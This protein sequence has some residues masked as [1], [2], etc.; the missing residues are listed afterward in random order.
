MTGLSGAANSE[1]RWTVQVPAGV[2]QLRIRMSGGT[3]DADLYVRQGTQPTTAT[4]TCR[5]YLSGNNEACTHNNPQAG[6][7]HVMVRG[8]SAYSGVT[9]VA[10]Y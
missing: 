5:P 1:R 7:W 9:L 10:E 3:G 8:Y 2:S 6:T 4:Y